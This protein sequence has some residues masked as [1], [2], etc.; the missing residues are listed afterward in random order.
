MSNDPTQR[1][2]EVSKY[3]NPVEKVSN[4]LTGLFWV[5]VT[6]ALIVLYG[7]T[8]IPAN[9]QEYIQTIF[10]VLV[11][12]QL[13]LSLILKLYLIPKAEHER[14][15][16]LLSDA[17]G[18]ALS[19]NETALYYNN[20][21]SPS[22]LRLGASTM[23]NA[24]FSKEIA[25]DMLV[26]KRVVTG[27]YVMA[28]LFAVI[29]RDSGL[30]IITWITQVIFSGQI[31]AQWITMETLRFR[32]KQVYDQLYAHFLHGVGGKTHEG[33]ATILDAFTAYES[34]KAVAGIKLSTKTFEKLNS[35][36]TEEWNGIRKKLKMEQMN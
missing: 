28:W 16:Q 1:L 15:K 31:V 17:F 9:L 2:D 13:V 25:K 34:T 8:I 24:F 33:I 4:V 11:V 32:C 35:R 12:F 21:Y 5:S 6:F 27:I 19:N 7:K 18:V 22:L 14:R 26:S 36:L 29:S 10:V 20:T 30:A 3:Y 23:E